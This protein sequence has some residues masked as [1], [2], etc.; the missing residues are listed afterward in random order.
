EPNSESNFSM[1]PFFTAALSP[2]TFHEI[3][4]M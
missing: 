3:N 4:L 2:F 1:N